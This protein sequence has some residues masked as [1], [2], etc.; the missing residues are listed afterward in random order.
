MGI[1]LEGKPVAERIRERVKAEVAGYRESLG[2]VP[3]LVGVLVGESP[4]SQSYLRMKE[5]AC[6][7]LGLSGR[8]L[9]LAA[10][11]P[12]GDLK[13]IIDGLN[14]DDSVDAILVQ[15]PLPKSFGTQAVI[16]WIDPRKDVD[17]IHPA[18]LGLLLQNEPGSRACTPLGCLELIKSTGVAIEGKDVVVIGRSLIVGKPLA[19]MITNENGTVTICHSK[20]KNL[21]QV[22]ARADILVAAMGKPGFVGPEFVKE[23][24][25]VID[26]GSNSVADKDVVRGLFGEDAKRLKEIDDRGYTW[27]GD[28]QPRVIDKAGWLT[29]SPGGV[30]PLTIAML[31]SNTLDCF[32]R[33]RGL[34]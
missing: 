33:R 27:I 8:I 21:A 20:T 30:G 16:S 6:Q 22:A 13:K 17:G 26:V 15:L 3:G 5:K 25:V 24:A 10:D 19:A 2:F 18:S 32:K 14:A 1:W 7:S 4:A 12:P 11:A 9:A 31:M 29:P 23:G 28:V 34:S